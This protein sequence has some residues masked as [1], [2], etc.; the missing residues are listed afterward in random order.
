MAI[1]TPPPQSIPFTTRDGCALELGHHRGP[2]SPVLLVHGASAASDTF[3]I[4][5]TATL[6]DH[7]LRQGFDVWTLD[8]RASKRRVQGV[9]CANTSTDF[10]ID[11]AATHD[12]PEAIACMR[13]HGVTGKVGVVGHCMGGAIITQGI[14]QGMLPAT[15]VEN[16]VVTALGLFYRA[17]I[18]N[19]VKAQDGVLEE[20]LLD[21]RQALL[22]PTKKWDPN[23]CHVDPGDGDWDPLLQRPY[24][25]WL[26]TPLR[27]GCAIDFCHRVSYMFGMPYLPDSIPTIHDHDLPSQFGYIPMQFLLH[28]TQNLRRGFAAPFVINSRGRSLASDETYLQHEPF[29]DRKLTLITGDL[30]SLWHRDSIDTMHE[31]LRLGRRSEQPREV[32]KYVLPGYGHQDLYWGIKAPV[33]VFPRIVEGLRL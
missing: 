33:D 23:L 9:Y 27:H 3:R 25:V 2:G 19:V 32:R 28:C 10:T 13:D 20:L 21:K 30:N 22:H 11:A 6:V 24:E 29:R 8:W 5:E 12:V 26:E 14:A 7:L 17:A 18:D 4:G 16:V 15:D 31:W 1:T